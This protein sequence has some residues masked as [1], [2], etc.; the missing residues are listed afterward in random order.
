MPQGDINGKDVGKLKSGAGFGLI[1]KYDLTEKIAAEVNFAY[2]SHSWDSQGLDKSASV[3]S[4][5]A[6]ANYLI[7]VKVNKITPYVG[8][9]LTL[10]IRNVGGFIKENQKN[11][12]LSGEEI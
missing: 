1:G 7:P 4:L 8:G 11:E 3:M 6:G 5:F 2:S 12:N 10:D 9:G